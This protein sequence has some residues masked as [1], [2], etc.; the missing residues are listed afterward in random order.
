MP[1]T[2]RTSRSLARYLAPGERVVH[3]CRRHPV[4]LLRPALVWLLSVVVVGMAAAWL[5]RS[6][7]LYMVDA[8]GLWIFLALTLVLGYRILRWY[9][10]RY[11][12]TNQRV[13][14]LEGIVSIKVSGVALARV[15]ETSYVR[16]VWG[17]LLGYGELKLDSPGEQLGLATLRYLP[18]PDYVYRLVSSLLY[19][20]EGPRRSGAPT[21]VDPSE[22]DTGELP[23]AGP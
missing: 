4:L 15:T 14:L 13:L 8:A 21:V 9:R 23:P 11:V 2:S 12:I 18:Q 7:G 17:R 22:R 3:L 5:S 10:E 20:D 16:S 19:P 1:L 6:T